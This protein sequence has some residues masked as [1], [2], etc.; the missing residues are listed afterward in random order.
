MPG[1]RRTASPH[2]SGPHAKKRQHVLQKLLHS[3]GALARAAALADAGEANSL[4]ASSAPPGKGSAPLPDSAEPVAAGNAAVEAAC[5][6]DGAP[7]PGSAT[8]VAAG[9]AA[10]AAAACKDD[11]SFPALAAEVAAGSAAVAAAGP[12]AEPAA[13]ETVDYKDSGSRLWTANPAMEAGIL[14]DYGI[15]PDSATPVATAMASGGCGSSMELP[16]FDTL[17]ELNDAE[18]ISCVSLDRLPPCSQAM[19]PISPSAEIVRQE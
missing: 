7:V 19:V 5:G 11:G 1:K 8:P 16:D 2:K 4:A 12:T 6:Q 3:N 9:N 18:S 13:V 14:P 17:W 15:L 10:E